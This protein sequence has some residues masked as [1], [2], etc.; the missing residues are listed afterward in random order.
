VH[1]GG[2]GLLNQLKAVCECPFGPLRVPTWRGA[3]SRMSGERRRIPRSGAGVWQNGMRTL[4]ASAA[5][6]SGPH[7]RFSRIP[8]DF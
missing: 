7:R 3:N 6:R 4:S 5:G 8:G 1:G 2:A